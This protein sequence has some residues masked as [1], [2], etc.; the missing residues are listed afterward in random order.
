MNP[1]HTHTPHSVHFWPCCTQASRVMVYGLKYGPDDKG[2]KSRQDQTISLFSNTSRLA[3]APTQPP[4]QWVP[5]FFPGIK[6][7]GA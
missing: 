2:F 5:V 3:P 7:A 6:A 4:V 1:N